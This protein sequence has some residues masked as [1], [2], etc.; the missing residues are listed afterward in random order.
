MIPTYSLYTR[1]EGSPGF[2]ILLAKCKI[3]DHS[4]S[5]HLNS[6]ISDLKT[7]LFP[8]HKIDPAVKVHVFLAPVVDN[9]KYIV[10]HEV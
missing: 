3:K 8:N 7:I 5:P 4:A 10:A 1:A 2:F 6:Q 9:R